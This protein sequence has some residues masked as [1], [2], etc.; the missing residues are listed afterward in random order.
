VLIVS[1]AAIAVL[2]DV[3]HQIGIAGL[4][5]LERAQRQWRDVSQRLAAL[6]SSLDGI[7]EDLQRASA[8]LRRCTQPS[9]R[10][11][12]GEN[13]PEVFYFADRPFAAGQMRY[14]SNFYSSSGQQREAIDRWSRQIVPIAI[15]QAGARFDAEFAVEYPLLADYLRTHYRKAGSMVI[16][17]GA[18]V[19]IWVDSTRS[20][21]TDGASG[22]PCEVSRD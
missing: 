16:E 6:P 22:L 13:L 12:M 10:I 2:A 19:D 18:T 4:N 9:D 17:R 11:F 8:Y 21:T 15:T 5:D 3:P 7:D 14:F 1:T 20:F